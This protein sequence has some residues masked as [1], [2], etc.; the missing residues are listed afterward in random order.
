MN[1]NIR[2]GS[3]FGIPFYVNPSWFLVL[4]LVTLSY[5]GALAAQFPALGAG[6]PWLLGLFA[7]LLLFASVLAHELGHSFV[8]LKQGINVQSI[9]LFLF[10]GLASLEKESKTPGEAFWVAIAG[11]AVS[12]TLSGLLTAL[13]IGLGLTGPIGAIVSLL[14]SINLV[15]A[16]F[17]LIPGLPLDGGNILKSA[18]WKITGDPYKGTVFASR[19]GQI[20]GWIAIAFGGYSFISGGSFWTLLIGWFLLQNAGRS[21]QSAT[22]QGLLAQ[23][24]AEDAVTSDSPVIS[25]ELSLREFANDYVIGKGKWHKFLVTDEAGQLIGTLKVDDLKTISTAHWPQTPVRD[26]TQP[27][28]LSETVPADQPLL[29]VV[30]RLEQQQIT[31][32]PV[33]RE[34]GSVVGILEK[35]AIIRLLQQKAEAKPA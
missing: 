17:N 13:N 12:I 30:Q 3:L 34:N 6:L 16:L 18:V 20:I 27:I 9:T 26:L 15:L 5:G 2:V 24:K 33:V 10:G 31:Q 29:E 19:A 11:P 21:A 7:A 14:A 28:D 4:G 23:L 8:A 35:T 25:A 32:V 22:I 1:G